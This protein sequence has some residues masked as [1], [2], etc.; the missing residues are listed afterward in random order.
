M[1]KLSRSLSQD[2]V[3]TENTFLEI[4]CLYSIHPSI[5]P[6]RLLY[7]LQSHPWASML[8]RNKCWGSEMAECRSPFRFLHNHRCIHISGSSTW[9]DEDDSG[10][11]VGCKRLFEI[12]QSCTILHLFLMTSYHNHPSFCRLRISTHTYLNKFSHVRSQC[13]S[14]PQIKWCSCFWHSSAFRSDLTW[15]RVRVAGDRTR[16]NIERFMINSK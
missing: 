14:G 6:R 16:W 2:R 12:L 4:K 8:A 1:Y 5:D 7:L 13:L 10:S 9:H 15:I 11:E 3:K